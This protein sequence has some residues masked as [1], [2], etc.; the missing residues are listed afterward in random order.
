VL[1]AKPQLLLMYDAT[2]GVDVGTKAEIFD[3]M[4]DLAAGGVAIVFYSTDLTE[5]LTTCDRVIVMHDGR[6][7]A[8]LADDQ[9]THEGILSAV[10][11][12]GGHG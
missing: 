1:E 11:G 5:L 10:L 8:T 4:H 9:L 3:L 6:I 7:R 2:R 12:G